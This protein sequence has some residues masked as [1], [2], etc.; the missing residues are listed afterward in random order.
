MS[1][2]SE[3]MMESAVRGI[4]RLGVHSVR[5][6]TNN[7][8]EGEKT[9]RYMNGNAG[10]EVTPELTDYIRRVAVHARATSTYGLG[11]V[12]FEVTYQPGTQ[13]VIYGGKK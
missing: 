3:T 8:G 1:S 10:V 11:L 7:E 5:A 9:L 2:W 12:S 4:H 13:P 6:F